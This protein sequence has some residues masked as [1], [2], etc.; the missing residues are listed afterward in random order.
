M[1]EAKKHLMSDKYTV[2]ELTGEESH[3]GE[4]RYK[5]TGPRAVYFLMR[6]EKDPHLMFVLNKNMK[7]T[8]IDGSGW[9]SDKSGHLRPVTPLR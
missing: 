2:E 5:V 3:C 6:T 9:W 8:K 1:A 7:T 4:F